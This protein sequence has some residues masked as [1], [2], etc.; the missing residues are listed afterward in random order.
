MSYLVRL[1]ACLAIVLS[2][3]T[4]AAQTTTRTLQVG[5]TRALKTPSQAAAVARDGDVIAIDS[6]VYLG[7]VASWRQNNLTLRGV[8]T[9]RAVLRANGRSAGGKGIWVISGANV[10]VENIEF[11]EA[12]VPDLN[13]AGIRHEGG[14]LLTVVNCLFRD[15]ENGILSTTATTAEL[16][17]SGSEFAR[18]GYGDGR[19]HG[20]YTNQLRKLTVQASYFHDTPVGHLIKSRAQESRIL[21]NRIIDGTAGTSSYNIDL[22]NGGLGY[23]IGNEIRQST[24]TQNPIMIAYAAE[25]VRYADNRLFLID[26]V[27]VNDLVGRGTFLMNRGPNPARL[28]NNILL[29]A[30]PVLSGTGVLTNNLL[31]T[32]AGGTPS[33]TLLNGN[34][35]SGNRITATALLANVGANDYRLLAGSPAIGM[36][37]DPKSIL[38]TT[39]L[40][41]SEYL[42]ALKLKYRR[43]T[44]P[45]DAG[46]HAYP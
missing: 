16:S 28:A 21:Y 22:P 44:A 27:L 30:G 25:G 15:N 9:T 19:S 37:V 38:G 32:H 39:I 24:R 42:H 23:V 43:P 11:A 26:N 40:V 17:I 2:A 46:A 18:N 20:I 12:K 7:D 8:G 33:V 45:F 31:A 1:L 35:N 6:A 5:P 13:G 36:G 29:G 41:Q 4:A 34:G 14:G 10:R 3:A